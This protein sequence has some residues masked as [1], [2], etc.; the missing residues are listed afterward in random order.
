M[1]TL[2]A[3]H[4]ALTVVAVAGL[5][6]LAS[7]AH[8]DDDQDVRARPNEFTVAIAYAQ[9]RSGGATAADTAVANQVR[10]H[11]NGRRLGQ[12]VNAYSISC[13]RTI[14][15]TTRG[16]GLAQRAAVI[17]VA[18]A[19]TESSL[20][21]Y[22]EAVDHDSLGLFQQ[23][24]SQGWG[25]PHQLVDPVYA[26]NAFLGAMLRKFPNNAWMNGSIGRICQTVQ[27]SAYPD[28]YNY[29]VHDAELIVSALWSQ[30]PN[31]DVLDFYLSDDP[32]SSVST[33]PVIQYG[34][35]P[36]VPVVGD[37]NGDGADT[38]STYLPV[39]GQFFISNDPATG[40]A[41]HI[42]SYG[43]PGAVPLV[44]DWDG[45]GVDNI[46]VRMGNTFYLRTSPV[47]GN[48]ETTISL[49]YGDI[50]DIP[51]VG[52][53]DGDNKDNIG[54]HKPGTFNFYLRTTVNTDPTEIT[55]VVPYGNPGAVPLVGDWNGDGVDNVG[56]R[57][58]STFYFRTTETN[59]ATETTT[60]ISYG[61]G[62]PNTEY[63]LVGDWNGD[64]KDTQGIVY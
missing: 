16:R 62:D 34:N 14:V 10:P 37:W 60:T 58:G 17:A 12:S 1:R 43:N 31:L 53:W 26:T 29:E 11:M 24:P 35:S 42:V 21:N 44:G 47:T 51:L 45:D 52:D 61:N 15:E 5:I 4:L 28:A 9:C 22:T 48:A 30:A 3:R 8:A 39:S 57:M 18:T 13:A 19:I 40:Q 50:S 32:V 25:A 59:N 55:H 38:V 36:M 54:V 49:T 63:P 56:V 64:A 27:V 33:R 20:H 6:T 7:P 2:F 23:R 46:G 41:E